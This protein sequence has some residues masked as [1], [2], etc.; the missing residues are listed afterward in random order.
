[1]GRTINADVPIF[2]ENTVNLNAVTTDTPGTGI[3]TSWYDKMSVFINVSV[4]TGAVTVTIEGSPDNT[5]W[6]ELTATTYTATVKKDVFS[7]VDFF[8]YTRVTTT[9]QSNSTVTAT[10]TAR[11]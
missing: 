5:T 9:T 11:S 4:N 7:Y 2:V 6:Y 10:I 3:D 8:P 1:M